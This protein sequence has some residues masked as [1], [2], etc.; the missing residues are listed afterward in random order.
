MVMVLSF[1]GSVAGSGAGDGS[2]GGS[3]TDVTPSAVNW[4][5]ISVTNPET[6]VESNATQTILAIDTSILIRASW[7]SSSP[8]PAKGRWY[9]N[10][11]A[12]TGFVATPA[13]VTASVND[14]LYFEMTA[15]TAGLFT[16]NYD[17]GT[18]TVKN[19]TD[20]STTIDTFAFVVQY[21]PSFFM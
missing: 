16:G 7:T 19:I 4:A 3:G 17:G 8:S 11:A 2:G 6:G 5:D 13:D 12:V 20:A 1:C 9:K 10:G 21:V 14:V 15:K 18:V